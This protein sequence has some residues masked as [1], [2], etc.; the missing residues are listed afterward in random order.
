MEMVAV[1]INTAEAIE[2]AVVMIRDIDGGGG[3][4]NRKDGGGSRY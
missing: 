1:A 4:D 3:N 2:M